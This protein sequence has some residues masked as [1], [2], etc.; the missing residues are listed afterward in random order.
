MLLG[1]ILIINSRSMVLINSV[2][3]EQQEQKN[4]ALFTK[5]EPKN[6]AALICYRSPLSAYPI[7]TR[8]KKT[9]AQKHAAQFSLLN[10]WWWH[11]ENELVAIVSSPTNT[12]QGLVFHTPLEVGH[13]DRWQLIQVYLQPFVCPIMASQSSFTMQMDFYIG[14]DEACQFAFFL[15]LFYGCHKSLLFIM[16]QCLVYWDVTGQANSLDSSSCVTQFRPMRCRVSLLPCQS[17]PQTKLVARLAWSHTKGVNIEG[18]FIWRY[19]LQ[20]LQVFGNF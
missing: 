15:F 6:H 19:F 20:E 7:K 10:Y 18:L 12:I 14:I 2:N 1:P 4:P 17:S 13:A 16:I 9:K 3:H 11:V 5:D 8:T